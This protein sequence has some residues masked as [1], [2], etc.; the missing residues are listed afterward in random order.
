MYREEYS[1][2]HD[3]S[4]IFLTKNACSQVQNTHDGQICTR[5]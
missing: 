4:S 2:G 1:M 3:Q 5:R